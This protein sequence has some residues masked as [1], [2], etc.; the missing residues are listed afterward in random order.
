YFWARQSPSSGAE[1]DYLLTHRGAIYP[2][3]VKS[4]V[5]GKLRS[6][7]QYLREFPKCPKG[8]VFSCAPYS[9][10]PEQ[11]LVFLPL[12]Y[13]YAVGAGLFEEKEPVE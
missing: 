12:Y 11:K 5:A 13:A 7:H 8:Y 6:L 1:V 2:I 4:G 3:E 10:L 9:E